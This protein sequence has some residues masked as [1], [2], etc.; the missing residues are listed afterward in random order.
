MKPF[1]FFP[2]RFRA[3]GFHELL[4]ESQGQN[5]ASTVLHVPCSLR[6][7]K[8][9]QLKERAPTDLKNI[10]HRNVQ[11]FRGG[12]VFKA[13]RLL[14]HSTLGLSVIKKR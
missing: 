9:L 3:T 1:A 13:N 14:Y 6:F 8:G 7:K 12:L 4:P 11:R 10:L 5:L 2:S